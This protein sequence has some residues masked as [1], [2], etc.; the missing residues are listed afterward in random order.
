[1]WQTSTISQHPSMEAELA[2]HTS[3]ILMTFNSC[4]SFKLRECIGVFC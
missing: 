1:L 2:S 4:F 3:R